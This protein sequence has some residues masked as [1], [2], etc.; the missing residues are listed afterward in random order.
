LY[1]GVC[2]T[3]SKV[4]DQAT[5]FILAY[6]TG[7]TTNIAYSRDKNNIILFSPK[8]KSLEIIKFI[9]SEG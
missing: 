6:R 2:L 4:G 3:K 5:G 1:K 7:K 8:K 9:D